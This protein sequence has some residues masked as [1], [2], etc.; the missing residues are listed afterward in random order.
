LSD[1]V[2]V[3]DIVV[4]AVVVV[5][6]VSAREAQNSLGKHPLFRRIEVQGS[7][8]WKGFRVMTKI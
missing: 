6:F 1:V 7:E 2:V 8:F 4:D 3:T 5:K